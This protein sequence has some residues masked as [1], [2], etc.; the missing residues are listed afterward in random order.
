M[1]LLA[2]TAWAIAECRMF[3]DQHRGMIK[4]Q[5]HRKLPLCKPHDIYLIKNCSVTPLRPPKQY[6]LFLFFS[7][8]YKN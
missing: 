4:A 6:R 5:S 8:D 3:V 1:N 2:L 7:V